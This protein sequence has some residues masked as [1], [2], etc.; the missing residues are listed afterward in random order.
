M[1]RRVLRATILAGTGALALPACGPIEYIATVPADA[2][3][4][5]AEAKHL[6]GDKYAPYEMTA[7]N[8][9]VHKSRMLA[10]Y[11]RFHSSV[12]FGAKAAENARKAKRIAV[13]KAALPEE[14]PPVESGPTAAPV[15]VEPAQAVSITPASAA[16]PVT[17][18]P[19]TAPQPTSITIIH[20][21]QPS[22]PPAPVETQPR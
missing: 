16:Q 14:K 12:T 2:N 8:E 1:L 4:A 7:A 22:A 6:S 20:T 17:V 18:E 15:T 5:I 10:G 21:D 11:A 3:G 13:E 9:Y 19:V